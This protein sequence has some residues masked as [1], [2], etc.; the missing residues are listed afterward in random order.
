M[1][2]RWT[3]C[4]SRGRLLPP[5]SPRRSTSSRCTTGA[6]STGDLSITTDCVD[7]TDAARLIRFR[8]PAGVPDPRSFSLFTPSLRSPPAPWRRPRSGPAPSGC[9]SQ[10]TFLFFPRRARR[11]TADQLLA[12]FGVAREMNGTV[13]VDGREPGI[14]TVPLMPRPRQVIGSQGPT[15]AADQSAV[16]ITAFHLLAGSPPFR[17]SAPWRSSGRT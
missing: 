3:G 9:R 17:N 2:S 10:P 1:N 6:S 15:A 7:G 13:G 5:R 16:A 14:G 4:R 12:D 11:R 8:S